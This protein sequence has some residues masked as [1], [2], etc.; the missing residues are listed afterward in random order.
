MHEFEIL[1]EKFRV[2]FKLDY[3]EKSVEYLDDL[4]ER[5]RSNYENKDATGLIN[6]MAAFLGQCI[7]TK[8]GGA[9]G[10]DD[11]IPNDNVVFDENTK[12]FPVTKTAKQFHNGYIDS[13]YSFY[14]CIPA[15][16]EMGKSPNSP[17]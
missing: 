1:A 2:Q 15:I 6:A 10:F 8:Y 12:I 7:I 16:L 9:W 13:I 3:D 11:G 17:S 14:M 5:A 4:I